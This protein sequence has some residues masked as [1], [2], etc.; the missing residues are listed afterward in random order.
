MSSSEIPKVAAWA[1]GAKARHKPR[2]KGQTGAYR[3]SYGDGLG[4]VEGGETNE[5]PALRARLGRDAGGALRILY[6]SR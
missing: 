3:K 2:V 4:L 5:K 6:R 1:D